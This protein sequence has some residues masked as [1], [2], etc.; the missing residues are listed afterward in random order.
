MSAENTK[1]PASISEI[2]SGFDYD[3]DITIGAT[4]I[5]LDDQEEE[6]TD[7]GGILRSDYYCRGIHNTTSS[8]MTIK[9]Q[10]FDQDSG[11]GFRTVTIPAGATYIMYVNIAVIGGT[12]SGST[13][14]LI[15]IKWKLREHFAV[16]Y[17]DR[18]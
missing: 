4:D 9:Y 3:E 8:S 13:A 1:N 6:I 2:T 10:L 15:N 7:F 12:G 5:D 14:G 11:S 18:I 16:K 17:R